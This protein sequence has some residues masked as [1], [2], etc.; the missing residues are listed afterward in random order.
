MPTFPPVVGHTGRSN[1]LKYYVNN[2]IT[3]IQIPNKTKQIN[4]SQHADDTNL[5]LENQKSIANVL[6]FFETLNKATGTTTNLEKTIL[7]I[8]TNDTLKIQKN[9]PDITIKEQQ[10]QLKF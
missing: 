2:S 10:Q 5:F 4:I 7:P 8:N 3:G 1:N 6:R 9:T